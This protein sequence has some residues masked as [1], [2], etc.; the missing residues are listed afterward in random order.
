[1]RTDRLTDLY[2]AYG[3]AIYARCRLLL[4]DAAA[5]EDAT[6]ETF[7]RVYRHLDSV[8]T[9]REGLYWMSSPSPCRPGG[10]VFRSASKVS[11]HGACGHRVSWA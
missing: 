11:L 7:L 8:P 9:A 3:P 4:A 2:R 10:P 1:V 5:A 6:Q